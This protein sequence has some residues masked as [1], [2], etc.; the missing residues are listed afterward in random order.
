MRK[1]AVRRLIVVERSGALVGI[2]SLDDII[3][4]IHEQITDVS[5]LISNEVAK[6]RK[7]RA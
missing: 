4:L 6:E 1:N 5:A 3:E 7:R 2:L